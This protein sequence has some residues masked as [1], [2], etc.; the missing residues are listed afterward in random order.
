MTTTHFSSRTP[1]TGGM[2]SSTPIMMVCSAMLICFIIL[3]STTTATAK[4][5]PQMEIIRQQEHHLQEEHEQQFTSS[6]TAGLLDY[7]F[8]A[9][10]TFPCWPAIKSSY[11][12]ELWEQ[13]N[14]AVYVSS[15]YQ[16][17]AHAIRDK[18]QC[19]TRPMWLIVAEEM[20]SWNVNKP[21]VVQDSEEEKDGVNRR[22]EGSPSCSLSPVAGAMVMYGTSGGRRLSSVVDHQVPQEDAS[23]C[24]AAVREQVCVYARMMYDAFM[25][26]TYTSESEHNEQVTEYADKWAEHSIT[27]WNC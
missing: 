17:S 4:M 6:C 2:R 16:K 12:Q 5:P 1:T 24:G 9:F 10:N 7:P 26:S 3:V 11:I 14:V 18:H 21:Q 25:Y 23:P 19:S 15:P 22:L 20:A 8:A 27:V 13:S